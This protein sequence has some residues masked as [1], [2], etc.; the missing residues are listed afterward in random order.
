MS[1]QDNEKP[2]TSMAD[3]QKYAPRWVWA[4]S[5]SILLLTVA[6]NNAGFKPVVDAYASRITHELEGDFG[7]QQE[8]EALKLRLAELEAEIER[9]KELA[10]PP[11]RKD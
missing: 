3:P 11:A 6:L 9:L 7:N 2:Q 1:D 5:G 4:L 8:I 10:H